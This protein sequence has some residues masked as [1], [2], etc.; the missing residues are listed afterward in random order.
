M[1][2]FGGIRRPRAAR[3]VDLRL[4]VQDE[5]LVLDRLA[6]C[7]LEVEALGDLVVEPAP[8]EQER[9]ALGAHGLERFLRVAQQADF[10]GPVVRIQGD[11]GAR[12]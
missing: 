1:K 9:L 4:V 12:R 5:T 2:R 6:Q 7:H 11:A 10:V 8:V 3:R